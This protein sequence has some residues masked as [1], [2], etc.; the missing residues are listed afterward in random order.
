MQ[1]Y[2]LFFQA[3]LAISLCAAC[4]KGE[5]SPTADELLGHA[6][7]QAMAYGGYRN[8]DRA[9]APTVQEIK[10]DLRLLHAM[11]I[12]ILRT[13]HARLYGHAE[14]VL[15]AISELK[16]HDP[17]FDMYVMLGAWM[18]C[19]A[20]WSEHPNHAVGDS[21]NNAAEIA[22]ATALASRYPEIV[23]IIAVGNESMVHWAASYYVAPQVITAWVK[24]LQALKSKGEL[25][26]DLWITSSDNYASWGGEANYRGAD[27]EELIRAVD[28]ISLHSYPFHDTHY[29]PEF[30]YVPEPEE[31]LDKTT[32]IN[33]AMERAVKRVGAQVAEVRRYLYAIGS[34]KEIHIGETGWASA[35]NSLYGPSGSRAADEYKQHLYYQKIRSWCDSMGM[36]CFY[37]EAFDEPWKDQENAMGSENH[38][39]LFD[40]QGNAK[41][42]LHAMID[43]NTFKGL[44]RNG[45]ETGVSTTRETALAEQSM[46]PPFK[47]AMPITLLKYPKDQVRDAAALQILPVNQKDARSYPAVDLKINCWEGSCQAFANKTLSELTVIP[48]EGAWWGVA[49]EIQGQA[50]NFVDFSRGQL[51]FEMKTSR[52]NSSFKLGLLSGN[53]GA[54]TQQRAEMSFGPEGIKKVA[55]TWKEYSLSVATLISEGFDLKDITAPLLIS[56]QGNAAG[57]TIQIRKLRFLK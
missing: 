56:G 14:N 48:G 36:S 21:I 53:F 34:E 29:N 45:N 5:S 50:I 35:D 44:G 17:D 19:A 10:E 11:D 52:G 1:R 8:H 27:L 51:M 23:K 12:R 9:Q 54:G 16:A 46:M 26:A 25:P 37:F 43:A 47:S 42:P 7:Y 18:Q 22:K 15:K 32:I 2:I 57:D 20:A 28:Y 40:V 55:T 30:W 33:R 39:G 31:Q 6:K 13:Y 38:F 3:M 24:H 4:S 41:L 49:L